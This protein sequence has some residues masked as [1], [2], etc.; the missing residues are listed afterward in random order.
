[1]A[2]LRPLDGLPE[3][4]V[5][6]AFHCPGCGCLHWVRV[7][8][9]GSVWGW[10]GS[11]DRPTFTPSILSREWSEDRLDFTCHSF[12]RDGQIEFLGD[13]D[14]PLAGQTVPLPDWGEP[15]EG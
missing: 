3:G 14:H 5:R 4:E 1:M 6:Y 2:I 15:P 12:V 7:A 13:C 10:N 8:G 11:L 9:P